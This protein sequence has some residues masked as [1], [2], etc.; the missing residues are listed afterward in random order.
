MPPLPIT[1]PWD[2]PRWS[3]ACA[4]RR[5]ESGFTLVEAVVALFVLGIIFTALAAAAMGSLRASMTARVEQQ[6]IDFATEALEQARAADYY[7]LAN[8]SADMS[9]DPRVAVCGTTSCIDTG[10]GAAEP[11]VLSRHGQRESA[12]EPGLG[13]PVQRDP[14]HVVDLRVRARPMRRRTTS[15]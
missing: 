9:R 11:L 12:R 4:P 1:T 10:T 5:D 14:H 15:G 6:A 13:V 3:R 8:V 2:A 7:T